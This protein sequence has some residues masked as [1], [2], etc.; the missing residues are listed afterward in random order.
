MARDDERCQDAGDPSSLVS[1]SSTTRASHAHEVQCKKKRHSTYNP[2]PTTT[3][4]PRI[5]HQ[6]PY[7][8]RCV[9][10]FRRRLLLIASLL[11][12]HTLIL[13]I[14]ISHSRPWRSHSGHGIQTRLTPSPAFLFVGATVFI[15]DVVTYPT[16]YL[17]SMCPTSLS[18]L[19][20]AA[21]VDYAYTCPFY[22]LYAV[23]STASNSAPGI[24]TY[25]ATEAEYP[26]G[27]RRRSPS[28]S[29]STAPDAKA[30][31]IDRSAGAY[32]KGEAAAAQHA[33][34]TTSANVC[35]AP[36]TAT[37]SSSF[38]SLFKGPR[39][40]ITSHYQV[41]N[42]LQFFYMMTGCT[43]VVQ[44]TPKTTP[45]YPYDSFQAYVRDYRLA[46][47]KAAPPPALGTTGAAAAAAST[48]AR[49]LIE[50]TMPIHSN[51][52]TNGMIDG[53]TQ[54]PHP[55]AAVTAA[56]QP[57]ITLKTAFFYWNQPRLH[58]LLNAPV[59]MA[60]STQ[61]RASAFAA[62]PVTNTS[63]VSAAVAT[64]T[65]DAAATSSSSGS[66]ARYLPAPAK[67]IP[68]VEANT[69]LTANYLQLS[70]N[71]L[72]KVFSYDVWHQL[73]NQPVVFRARSTTAAQSSSFTAEFTSVPPSWHGATDS[74]A[75]T[76]ENVANARED[77][78][79]QT[80]YNLLIDPTRA[81]TAPALYTVPLNALLARASPWGLGN[82]GDWPQN[83]TIR[84]RYPA[85]RVVVVVMQCSSTPLLFSVTAT[86]ANPHH[87]VGSGQD[88][89]TLIIYFL[90]LLCY[91]ILGVVFLFLIVPCGKRRIR[92]RE[93]MRKDEEVQRQRVG[94][95]KS[96]GAPSHPHHRAT[97]PERWAG[98]E[99]AGEGSSRS[100]SHESSRSKKHVSK[101]PARHTH[102]AEEPTHSEDGSGR[103]RTRSETADGQSKGKRETK[104]KRAQ[105]KGSG[106]DVHE[107]ASLR[108]L[109]SLH[110]NVSF[111]SSTA[112][113]SVDMESDPAEH[114]AACSSRAK[115][116]PSARGGAGPKRHQHK[117]KTRE[118]S[119]RA[120]A[121]RNSSSILPSSLDDALSDGGMGSSSSSKDEDE[122]S[123]SSRSNDSSLY[124]GPGDSRD[125]H[126]RRHRHASSFT[127]SSDDNSTDSSFERDS[128]SDG[129]SPS[130]GTAS[131][132]HR[133]RYRSLDEHALRRQRS[134]SRSIIERSRRS[135]RVHLFS[136]LCCWA[137]AAVSTNSSVDGRHSGHAP[138][139]RTGDRSSRTPVYKRCARAMVGLYRTLQAGVKNRVMAPMERWWKES[140]IVI[141]YAPLQWLLLVLLVLKVLLCILYSVKFSLMTD[142]SVGA[143]STNLSLFIGS[144]IFEIVAGT[145]IIPV[146]MLV[147]MGWGLAFTNPLPTNKIVTVCLATLVMFTLYIFQA[148]CDAEGYNLALTVNRYAKEADTPRC[149]SITYT[150]ISLELACRVHNVF[151]MFLLSLWLSRSV[152]PADAEAMQ[153]Q[154]RLRERQLRRHRHQQLRDVH[155]DRKKR[156]GSAKGGRDRRASGSSRRSSPSPSS[157][158][159]AS[160]ASSAGQGYEPTPSPSSE[161]PPPIT[162]SPPPRLGYSAVSLSAMDVCLRYQGMWMPFGMLLLWYVLHITFA[163]TFFQPED[164][165]MVVAFREFQVFYLFAFIVIFMRTAS[166]VYV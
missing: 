109:H 114:A 10:V 143:T 93:L 26:S 157:A 110:S 48:E 107:M 73:T 20:P 25:S 139:R 40:S 2:H 119:A 53:A 28:A 7:S 66:C 106:D 52:S 105:A 71:I 39:S 81:C 147:G 4:N 154:R 15:K 155:Q 49:S 11:V 47:P 30:S 127:S 36:T 163:F 46:L 158:S 150:R 54:V 67:L 149:N 104:T 76:M 58:C 83:I 164:Y 136:I 35:S 99:E 166:P 160:T 126:R 29:P 13:F 37:G 24:A 14:P 70:S 102:A 89:Y 132:E 122:G 61:R 32:A 57:G 111:S 165:Y 121:R 34:T 5:A 55:S 142:A 78:Y 38:S 43:I 44:V 125:P 123:S 6:K 33:S 3:R 16:D 1:V 23:L 144:I 41:L 124:S 152:I 42:S 91:G 74:S 138:H 60:T 68:N 116:K 92:E 17:S 113:A 27:A 159:A 59:L 118:R 69:F 98:A 112:S 97:A 101:R 141:M 87:H 140:H 50:E 95:A 161:P 19:D 162:L 108:S 82:S 100:S 64:G 62:T 45:S 130:G 94:E 129:S 156:D 21:R 145:L 8:R 131:G 77:A 137:G 80:G 146:E 65:T 103:G 18:A 151:R 153:R 75:N 31:A 88:Y 135:K 96:G 63:T 133:N 9:N 117:Q 134:S 84:H 51:S 120:R 90:F 86:F 72:L 128:D 22:D 148:T 79:D 12:L 56:V 115:Q 85:A